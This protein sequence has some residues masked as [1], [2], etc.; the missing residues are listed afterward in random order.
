MAGRGGL[1][2]YQVVLP[3]AA[4]LEGVTGSGI[5]GDVWRWSVT[6]NKKR[7]LLFPLSMFR[8]ANIGE[9]G[10]ISKGSPLGVSIVL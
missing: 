8:G 2:V 5:P 7:E 3:T 9:I 4:L 10:G 6:Y 1:Q